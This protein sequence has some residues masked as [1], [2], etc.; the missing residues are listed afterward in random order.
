MNAEVRQT[1]IEYI[2]NIDGIPP[3]YFENEPLEIRDDTFIKVFFLNAKPVPVDLNSVDRVDGL[4]QISVYTRDGV[5]SID[6]AMIADEIQKHFPRN[7]KIQSKTGVIS[8]PR[9]G[10]VSPAITGDG[11][12]H[13]PLTL[14][15]LLFIKE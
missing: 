1:L 11:W 15:Y 2:L 9:T 3:V 13:V 4:F 12:Y 6:A 10:Y 7:K 8:I 14:S 5:G